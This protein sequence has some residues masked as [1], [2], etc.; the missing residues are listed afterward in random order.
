MNNKN[1]HL[2][3]NITLYKLSQ[4]NM[5][6]PSSK[7]IIQTSKISTVLKIIIISLVSLWVK[8]KIN[9]LRMTS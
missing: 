8:I 7:K 9:F 4:T 2:N 3:T 6:L 5:K 1:L